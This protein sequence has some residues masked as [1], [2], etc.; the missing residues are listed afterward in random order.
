MN[1]VRA[2][3][4]EF[5]LS[6]SECSDKNPLKFR[7]KIALMKRMFPRYANQIVTS[8]SNQ[9]FEIAV[10]LYKQ[11]F[12]EIF[13]VVGSDR[14]REFETTLNK[15]NDVKA[16]HGYYNF[17]N[18]NVLSVGERDPDAEGATGMSASKMRSCC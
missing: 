4:K 18:I 7:Q 16:R 15:Y 6:K 13:M 8:N 1:S 3:V 14:V 17:D 11:N 9:I 5:I 10:E 12:T 2:D